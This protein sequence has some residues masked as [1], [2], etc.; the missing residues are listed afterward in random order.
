M[1]LPLTTSP[2]LTT[3]DLSTGV[4]RRYFV[5]NTATHRITEV[6]SAQFSEFSNNP[7]FQTIS[8]PWVIMGNDITI[9]DT[10]GNVVYGVKHKNTEIIKL[11]EQ[12]MRGLSR[13]LRNPMEYF[14]GTVVLTP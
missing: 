14:Y 2:V 13:V 7:Y 12:R 5:K 4:I 9:T 1:R 11:Y 8:L 10:T 3:T 6:D